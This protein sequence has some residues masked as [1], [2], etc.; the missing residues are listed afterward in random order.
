MGSVMMRGGGVVRTG[1]VSG[2]ALNLHPLPVMVIVMGQT[3]TNSR[4]YTKIMIYDI[5][6]N[7][8]IGLDTY[9]DHTVGGSV[10][11]N[12]TTITGLIDGTYIALG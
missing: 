1:T 9:S 10:T 2:G 3:Y 7:T 4:F 11:V 8:G 12:G 6:R 5:G